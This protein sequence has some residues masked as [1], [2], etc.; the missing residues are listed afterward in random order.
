M[1]GARWSSCIPLIGILLVLAGPRAESDAREAQP[2]IINVAD[3][4]IAYY[5]ACVNA[6]AETRAEQW[7]RMLESKHQAFF[8]HAIYRRKAGKDREEFKREL[9]R[10]FWSEVAPRMQSIERLNRTA[11]AD[12]RGVLAAF[13]K[14]FPGFDPARDYYITI[15]F[16]FRGKVVDVAGKDV[17]AIGLESLSDD[18]LQFTITVAHELFHLYHFQFFSTSGAIYRKIWAEGMAVYASAV[19]VPGY[20]DSRYLGF[21]IEKMNRCH[22]LLPKMAAELRRHMGER[23]PALERAYLGAEE[24][25]TGIPPEAGYY[26]GLRIVASL[27]RDTPID[28]LARL[29][30]DRVYA[31]VEAELRKLEAGGAPTAGAAAERRTPA[32]GRSLRRDLSNRRPRAPGVAREGADGPTNSP[33]GAAIS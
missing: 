29:K 27:A 23:D 7:D 12:I 5:K 13:R 9:R 3:D 15:A 32:A 21:S 1:G 11:E 22:E 10:A 18:P 26:V 19:V 17:F 14:P 6:G 30:S 33:G 28:E 16:S 24:N 2:R 8:D 20:R 4:F 25:R 31:L